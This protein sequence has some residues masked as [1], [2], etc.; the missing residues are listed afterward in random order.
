VS[1]VPSPHWFPAPGLRLRPSAPSR[2]PVRSSTPQAGDTV[3][4]GVEAQLPTNLLMHSGT[5]T[6]KGNCPQS[7]A[8]VPGPPIYD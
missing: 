8:P 5:H 2:R 1:N 3:G 6:G 4:K 7:P